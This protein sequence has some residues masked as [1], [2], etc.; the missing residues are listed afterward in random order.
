MEI[1]PWPHFL[2]IGWKE[3]RDPHPLFDVTFYLDMNPDI[4]ASGA[5]PLLHFLKAGWKEGRD[6]HP[7]FD[8]AYYVSLHPYVAKFGINP[9]LHYLEIGWRQGYDPH[10]LF[11]TGYYLERYPDLRASGGNPLL[12]FVTDGGREWRK[13]SRDFDPILYLL[14]KQVAGGRPIRDPLQ[15]FVTGD[16]RTGKVP[17]DRYGC[18]KLSDMPWAVPAAGPV[19]VAGLFRSTKGLGESA[20]CMQ[21]ALECREVPVT[22]LDLGEA[23]PG[24]ADLEMPAGAPTVA[25]EGGLLVVHVNPPEFPAALLHI[26]QERLRSKKVIG[27][28][29]WELPRAPESWLR[30]VPYVD[31]IWVPSTF[32]AAAFQGLVDVPVRV[33]PHVVDVSETDHRQR[34][35]FGLPVEAMVCLC[36]C[37]AASS[38]GRKNPAG[39]IRA[40]RQAFGDSPDVLLIVKVSRAED[41]P[42]NYEALRELAG[43]APNIRFLTENLTRGRLLDLVRCSDVVLSLHR[44][45]GFGLIPAEAMLLGKPVVATAWSGNLDF[46]DADNSA[47]VGFQL[48][49][50]NDPPGEGY[51]AENQEWAYPDE[52][53]A[54]QWLIRLRDDPELRAALGHAASSDAQRRLGEEALVALLNAVVAASEAP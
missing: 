25:D 33:V 13:P 30:A 27:Y 28:W 32:V 17:A 36:V 20:R 46:M 9:I 50:V 29:A 37:D 14:D 48:G 51:S 38:L 23:I 47:L 15:H 45:E 44:S 22:C 18:A 41:F 19:A 4:A 2:H 8:V 42:A 11:D 6:P 10:P 3:G 52:S 16:Y 24:H 49:K 35:D 53:E 39:A 12:H 5:N 1:D 54:A 31:E 26:G 21:A 7:L 43:G 40:F 34:A